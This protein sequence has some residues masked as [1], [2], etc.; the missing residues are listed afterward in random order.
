MSDA[1]QDNATGQSAFP[2][3]IDWSALLARH[4]R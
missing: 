3:V 1:G 4:D 2:P